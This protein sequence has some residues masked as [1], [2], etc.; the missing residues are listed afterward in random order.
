MIIKT[1]SF[2]QKQLFYFINMLVVF[3]N[4]LKTPLNTKLLKQG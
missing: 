4:L 2:I 1:I 3:E